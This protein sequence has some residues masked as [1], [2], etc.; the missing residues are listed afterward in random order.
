MKSTGFA[1][2]DTIASEQT[3]ADGQA[4]ISLEIPVR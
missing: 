1:P 3:G 4:G 2:G